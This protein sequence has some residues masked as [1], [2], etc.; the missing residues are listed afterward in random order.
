MK[1][2][3]LFLFII[4]LFSSM[5][6]AQ[7]KTRAKPDRSAR[8]NYFK[9]EPTQF[10]NQEFGAQYEHYF[11]G[12]LSIGLSAG[13][14]R[15][16]LIDLIG[17]GKTFMEGDFVS[18]YDSKR[19]GYHVGGMARIYFKNRVGPYGFY[20]EAE[21]RTKTWSKNEID[22]ENGHYVV[23]LGVRDV[24]LIPKIGWVPNRSHWVELYLGLSI[25]QSFANARG[26]LYVGLPNG[27]NGGAFIEMDR[28]VK[29][30]VYRPKIG[31]AICF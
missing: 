12:R 21:I 15:G 27:D 22:I 29:R 16:G 4:S 17:A 24:Q 8:I 26:P 6:F 10:L 19:W 20:S 5:S 9:F 28:Q 25:N 14:N 1:L 30:T 3:V 2:I 23:R 18:T 13:F 31:V 11:D 7:E